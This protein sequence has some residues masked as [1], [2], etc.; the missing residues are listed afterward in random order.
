MLFRSALPGGAQAFKLK[1]YG[2]I[3]GV[4]ELPPQTVIKGITAR[5]LEGSVA[6]AVQSI[7]L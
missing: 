7:K 6:K 2:R 3:E 5:V 1:Q 4:F